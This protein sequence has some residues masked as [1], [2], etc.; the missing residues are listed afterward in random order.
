MKN[1]CPYCE[2]SATGVATRRATCYLDDNRVNG[3][4]HACEQG[5]GC[6]ESAH[7]DR[8][9]TRCFPRSVVGVGKSLGW[10]AENQRQ[11]ARLGAFGNAQNGSRSVVQQQRKLYAK[12][13]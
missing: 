3:S 8:E 5:R 9:S 10:F 12:R 13:N 11:S 4:L 7:I 1:F 2:L 6:N